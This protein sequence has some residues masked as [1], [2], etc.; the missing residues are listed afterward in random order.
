MVKSLSESHKTV[1]DRYG[2]NFCAA[3][4]TSLHQLGEGVVTTCCKTRVP[5]GNSNTHSYE[6]IMN[7]DHAKSVRA[8]FLR[9]EKP[10]Q[11]NACWA[12]EDDND[13]PANN[14]M[15]SNA[16]ALNQID[17][18]VTDTAPDGTLI[19]QHPAWLDLLWTNKCNFACVG[20]SPELSTTIATKYKKEFAIINGEKLENYHSNINGEWSM[21][22]SAKI[23]YILN[24]SDSITKIHL[25]GGEPFMQEDVYELLDALLKNNLQKKIKI[26]AHTNGSITKYKGIDLIDDYLRHWGNN[27]K[28]TISNDGNGSRGEY[29]RWGYKE[30]K[31]TDTYLRLHDYD[32]ELSIQTCYNLLNSLSIEEIGE[33]YYSTLPDPLYG[34]LTMWSG[35]RAFD[36]KLLQLVPELKNNAIEQ[37]LRLKDHRRSSKNWYVTIDGHINYINSEIDRHQLKTKAKNFVNG[38]NALDSARGT[39]FIETFPDLEEFYRYLQT[40]I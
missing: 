34:S 38:V 19:K 28:I 23:D 10:L 16:S 12:Y 31:W 9:G 6:E 26:W 4:F 25:N 27:C 33:W 5:I 22:N 32:I 11:C 17:A 3:P 35:H 20:C 14:R 29:I 15:F 1:V 30:S 8:Q 24:Y 40:I 36:P 18:A 21:D 37:L 2:K 39:N 13:Q 7:S